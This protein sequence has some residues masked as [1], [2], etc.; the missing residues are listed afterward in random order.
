MQNNEP[1]RLRIVA[2][3]VKGFVRQDSGKGDIHCKW[4]IPNEG[5]LEVLA[6]VPEGIVRDV[7]LRELKV[8][9]GEN[10]P[11]VCFPVAMTR[12]V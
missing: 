9:I 5:L 4:R 3:G 8:L 10:Y 11:T 12:R 7:S 6:H 2:A 1:S